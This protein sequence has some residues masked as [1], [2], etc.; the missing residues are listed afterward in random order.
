MISFNL[1]QFCWHSL[2]NGC[3]PLPDI[4]LPS[5]TE[6]ASSP[7]PGEETTAIWSPLHS[8]GLSSRPQMSS[9]EGGKG[10]VIL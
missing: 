6:E 4:V 1:K 8:G 5:S 3:D 2:F 7:W 9:V 10:N